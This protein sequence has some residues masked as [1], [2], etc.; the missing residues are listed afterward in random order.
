MIF[1]PF[2]INNEALSLIPWNA[3]FDNLNGTIERQ[4]IFRSSAVELNAQSPIKVNDDGN[5]NTLVF[6]SSS[7]ANSPICFIFGRIRYS[8]RDSFFDLTLK[9][10]SPITSTFFMK[11]VEG[12]IALS[13]QLDDNSVIP[14]GNLNVL[15]ITVFA[16]QPMPIDFTLFGM[17][18]RSNVSPLK[19]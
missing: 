8:G 3:S 7:K 5:S 12:I 14:C 6:F 18:R 2:G 9:Q 17:T 19:A 15:L 11:S 10:L 4:I 16:K 1:V 13:K